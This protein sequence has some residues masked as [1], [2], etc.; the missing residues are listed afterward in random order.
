MVCIPHALFRLKCVQII[1]KTYAL[2]YLPAINITSCS[3]NLLLKSHT[4]QHFNWDCFHSSPKINCLGL[5]TSLSLGLGTSQLA[6]TL[7][8]WILAL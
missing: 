8:S 1:F 3:P 4:L 6:L 2:I 5:G 7:T